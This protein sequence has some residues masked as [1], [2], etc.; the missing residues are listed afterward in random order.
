MNCRNDW[1]VFITMKQSGL[2]K[3]LNL[4]QILSKRLLVVT[5]YNIEKA[6]DVGCFFV[7]V[8]WQANQT[9]L[10][11]N[12][13]KYFRI[14]NFLSFPICSLRFFVDFWVVLLKKDVAKVCAS[15]FLFLVCRFLWFLLDYPTNTFG[16]LL[17]DTVLPIRS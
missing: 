14:L 17:M 13:P 9:N 5:E 2:L 7:K 12:S 3:I 8:L 10:S 16:L 11:P 15:N 6:P 4:P 1:D